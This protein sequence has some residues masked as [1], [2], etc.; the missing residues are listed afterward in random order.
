MAIEAAVGGD[1]C[2][3]VL[4]VS[5]YELPEA[6]DFDD[7]NWLTGEVDL[8]AGTTGSFRA[9][10]GVALRADELERFHDDLLSVVESLNGVA[11]LGH[12]EGQVGC[13]IALENGGGKLTAFVKEHIGSE[14]NV[15]ECKTD[16]SYLAQTILELEAV[17][18]EF[19]VRG[20]QT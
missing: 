3:L 8:V 2:Q 15:H 12:L 1:G 6:Q 17:L 9:T 14:L 10:H 20:R 19:P 18:K 7:A 16:Q 5:A 4:R 11:T 13:T